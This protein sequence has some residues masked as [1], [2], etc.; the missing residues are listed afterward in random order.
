MGTKINEDSKKE[1]SVTHNL[2]LLLEDDSHYNNTKTYLSVIN[3]FTQTD[4]I[5]MT[6]LFKI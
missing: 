1:V 6:R 4:H 2:V 5:F 3:T